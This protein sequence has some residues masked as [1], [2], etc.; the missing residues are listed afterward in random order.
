MLKTHKIG[1]TLA[2]LLISLA[3]LA[4]IATFTI[5][6]VLTSQRISAHNASAHEAASIVAAAYQQHLIS[7]S[8]TTNTYGTD[9][10][11]YLNYVS[12]NTSATIDD[13]PN[14]GGSLTCSG[15]APCLILHNGA[16]LQPEN[17][18]FG[19]TATTNYVAWT[20]DP[21]GT[22]TGNADSQKFYLYYNGRIVDRNSVTNNSRTSGNPSGINACANCNASWFTW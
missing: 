22:Y 4:E 14:G 11:Q 13:R 16:I 3:I 12:V 2:E 7:G 20:F 9:L 18:Y 15:T 21:D 8:L 1:F 6:K 17:N 5:P 10:T 19:G